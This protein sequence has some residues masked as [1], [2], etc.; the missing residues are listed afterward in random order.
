MTMSTMSGEL[1][2]NFPTHR[3]RPMMR[4]VQFADTSEMY[5]VDR[6][7]DNEDV[8]RHD[9]WY[10]RSDYS[11]MRLAI[12]KSVHEVR[13]RNLTGVPISYSGNDGSS[14]DCLIGI[15]H[16]LT[17]ACA[18]EVK[19]C[20]RR[21]VRAVLQEQA[22]QRMNPS[23]TFRWDAIAAASYVETRKAG[24]KARKLGKLHRDSI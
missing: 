6:H 12:Q 4:S 16:L 5:I 11:R 3:A 9:L 7:H 21:C 14:N 20:R 18:F 19:E 23:A 10:N 15:E 13:A 22:M 8:D 1:I 17:Q 2:V 24:V